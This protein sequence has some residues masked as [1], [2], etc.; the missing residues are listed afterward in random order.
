MWETSG[1][2]CYCRWDFI[3]HDLMSGGKGDEAVVVRVIREGLL[4][5]I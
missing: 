4:W 3:V 2:C 5:L 1:G